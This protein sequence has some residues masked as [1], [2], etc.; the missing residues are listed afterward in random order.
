MIKYCN[1]L[2][3]ISSMFKFKKVGKQTYSY[4]PKQTVALKSSAK[5]DH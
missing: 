2:I 3:R 5:K 4:R 1:I